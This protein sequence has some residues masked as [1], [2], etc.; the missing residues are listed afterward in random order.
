MRFVVVGL[1]G[2][3][4]PFWWGCSGGEGSPQGASIAY[5]LG[6]EPATLDPAKSTGVPEAV[7][8]LNMIEGLVTMGPDN[9]AVP[10]LA[11][12][13]DVTSDGLT[14][15]FHLRE[16]QWSNGDPIV[17]AD[18]ATQ[19]LRVLDPQT[20]SDYAYQ[21]YY[22]A[23]ARDYHQGL[24]SDTA[25][26]AIRA[27]DERTLRVGLASPTPY[28]APMLAHTV[29]CPFHRASAG[30]GP[31]QWRE[32]PSTYLCSGPFRL[33]QWLSHDRI[34]LEK[35]PRY[36]DAGAV[37]LDEITLLM[38]EK[39]S[40]AL[41]AFES[42]QLDV[43]DR[44]PLSAI[45]RLKQ[46]GRLR[47]TPLIGTY[48]VSFNCRVKPFDDVRVRRA[49]ALAIDRANIARFI[50]RAG[51]IPAM[52]FVPTGIKDAGG[53][54]EFRDAGG[55]YFTDA[56]Y[57]EARR[58]LSEAGYPQGQN[59]PR[60]EYLY[61]TKEGHQIIA[62]EF[63]Q[64]WQK[65]LGVHVELVNAEWK[66]YLAR[67]QAGEYQIARGAWVGDYPDPMTFLETYATDSE[68]NNSFWSNPAYDALLEAAKKELDP[69]RRM[70][71]L[72]EAESL[73]MQEMPLA[74]VY[75]YTQPYLEKPEIEGIQR[76][77]LGYVYFKNARRAGN[78][79]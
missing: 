23:G 17:A 58:L 76:T 41:A 13:W 16:A 59:L 79:G 63:Q 48:F 33:K 40:S 55:D 68:N 62:Q 24:T 46:E 53:L 45:E 43:M 12:S 71:M 8:I 73:M 44:P 9:Q 52:A 11:R 39:E 14:Y 30:A 1:L 4:A 50:T 78:G 18:F 22:I 6:T 51:E 15:T 66:V 29:F 61:N 35:N 65:E 2:F 69:V 60:I 47:F 72:H 54:R 7:V 74:P 25:A 34:V 56:N 20:A 57:G 75:F 21:L 28:F 27:V 10:A 67:K 19:W 3:I 26:I 77:A 32:Q 42:G 38:I 31:R 64:R 37:R 5:N 70:G 36:W 49:F